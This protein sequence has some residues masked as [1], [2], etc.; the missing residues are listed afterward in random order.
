[1]ALEHRHNQ[2]QTDSDGVSQMN[3]LTRKWGKKR[4]HKP[5]PKFDKNERPEKSHQG[6]KGNESD[7]ANNRQENR[8]K[9]FHVI[10]LNFLTLYV[11]RMGKSSDI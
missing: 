7:R 11:I 9:R 6:N 1:M 2:R 8:R 5:I 4:Y 10:L 3:S